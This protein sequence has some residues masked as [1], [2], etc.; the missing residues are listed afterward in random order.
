VAPAG[1]V[2]QPHGPGSQVPA[3]RPPY[4]A[5]GRPTAVTV[6]AWLTWAFSAVVVMLFSLMVLVMLVD[7]AAVVEALQSNREIAAQG[8]SGREILS[9]LWLTCAL[10]ITWALAAMALAVLAY[11]R[12]EIGRILL[13]VSAAVAALV[14]LLAVPVGWPHAVAALT[15]VALLNRRSTR[16]WF[17]RRDVMPGPPPP[18][19]PREK[20]PV[21]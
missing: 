16:A 12:V 6:A 13:M 2:Q 5:A 3:H 14:C 9:A 20:P 19:Q 10:C 4:A 8:L 17:A 15:C 18:R 1:T 11:R 7:H 21:W